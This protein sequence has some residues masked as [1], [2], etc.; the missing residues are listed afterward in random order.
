MRAQTAPVHDLP[1]LNEEERSVAAKLGFNSEDYARS[2]LAGNLERKDLERKA[3]QA[4]QVIERLASRDVP[5]LRVRSV[6]LKTLDGKFRFDID[7]NG[8][9]S[10]VFVSEDAMNDLL[11]SGSRAAEEN[12]SRIL[13]YGLPANW[14]AR[15]S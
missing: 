12:I 5:G 3:E 15:A 10:V 1:L 8:S 11:E 7:F 13:D 2:I 4:A 14:K 9:S 6:W